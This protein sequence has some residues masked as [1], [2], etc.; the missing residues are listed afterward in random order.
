[1]NQAT[2]TVDGRTVDAPERTALIDVLSRLQID[3]PA[4]C[5]HPAVKPYGACRLCLVEVKKGTKS[6]C[7]T[8]CNFPVTSGIEVETGSERTKKARR[9]MLELLLPRA[10]ED[11]T[12]KAHAEEYGADPGR[13]A[14]RP[15]ADGCI[16]CGLCVRVCREVVGARVLTYAGRGVTRTV[17]TAFDQLPEP[18]IGCGA[19]AAVCPTGVV[20]IALRA[21][22][23]FRSL[24]GPDRL[25]RYSLMGLT[26]AAICARSFMCESC[27]VEHRFA[28]GLSTHPIM[29]ASEVEMEPTQ[30]YLEQRWRARQ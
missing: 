17:G 13:F 20:N 14:P 29:L 16:L 30:R 18:C 1:M 15:E 26:P 21:A 11:R 25:C 5:H 2:F 22:E 6:R 4:L 24:D 27:E 8:S 7:V 23:R 10:P 3:V 19:C 9:L 28:M 12:L